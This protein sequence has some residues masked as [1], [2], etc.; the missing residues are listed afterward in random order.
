MKRKTP[1][2]RI[3]PSGEQ[4]GM[5]HFVRDRLTAW[6]DKAFNP[7]KELSVREAN[8]FFLSKILKTSPFAQY[9]PVLAPI[10]RPPFIQEESIRGLRVDD[11]RSIKHEVAEASWHIQVEALLH[12]ILFIISMADEHG[13]VLADRGEDNIFIPYVEE[14][15][16]LIFKDPAHRLR[17]KHIDFGE[18]YDLLAPAGGWGLSAQ[19]C[20]HPRGKNLERM[21]HAGLMRINQ[22]IER[23]IYFCDRNQSRL[24]SPEDV[25]EMNRVFDKMLYLI[26]RFNS[27]FN[28]GIRH[29]SKELKA[30]LSSVETQQPTLTL[31]KNYLESVEKARRVVD[32][33]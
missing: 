17:F 30:L 32:S 14:G 10:A 16:T 6:V 11:L 29:L 18:M 20:R 26:D 22:E 33:M 24:Q 19:S 12:T 21:P 1:D 4:K 13:I 23:V 9:F 8:L 15:G 27:P 7:A 3:S 28:S 5:T 2:G 31:N 25:A